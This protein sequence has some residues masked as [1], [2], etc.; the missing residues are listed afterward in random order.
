MTPRH[1]SARRL[2]VRTSDRV[3]WVTIHR[4][5]DRNALDS[6]TLTE[7]SLHLKNADTRGTRVI[8]YEGAG[9]EYFIGGADGVEMYQFSVEQAHTFSGRIQALFRS[10]EAS[11][12]LLISAIDGLCFGGGLEFALA[13]DLRIATDRS[14]MGLPETKLGIVPG[15]GGTQRL[16]RVIG[17]GRA[18]EMILTGR[19]VT[20]REALDA[21]LIHRVVPASGLRSE[22][23]TWAE[24]GLRIPVHAFEAAKRLTQAARELPLEQGL[25]LE[26]R[27]FAHCF[28]DS[29]FADRVREQLADGRLKSTVHTRPK[30]S[31]NGDV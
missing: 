15:G 7:L 8:I 2:V 30:G 3:D 20:A 28:E 22:A 11:S 4:P 25:N 24:R 9:A 19:L 14:R 17:A 5:G 1:E 6:E 31:G 18:T 21:G 26:A 27:S 16:P 10:M 13:C 23:G 29:F 12:M